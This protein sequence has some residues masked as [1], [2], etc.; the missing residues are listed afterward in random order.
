MNVA[1]KHGYVTQDLFES[2][3]DSLV[4]RFYKIMPM[5][6]DNDPTLNSYLKS[7][8]REL[9]GSKSLILALDNNPYFIQLIGTVQYFIDNDINKE[10]CATEVK[11]CISISKKLKKKLIEKGGGVNGYL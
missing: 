9:C 3:L 11:K 6:E 8:N 2:Y 7:F 4:G 10:T 1:T 5:K